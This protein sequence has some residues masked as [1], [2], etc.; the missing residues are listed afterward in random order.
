MEKSSNSQRILALLL[1]LTGLWFSVRPGRGPFLNSMHLQHTFWR[2]C[3]V[4]AAPPG[5]Q[6]NHFPFQLSCFRPSCA[7]TSNRNETPLSGKWNYARLLYHLIVLSVPGTEKLLPQ[8]KQ[9][10]EKMRAW[11]EEVGGQCI[12]GYCLTNCVSIWVMI[13]LHLTSGSMNR[14]TLDVYVGSI[15]FGNRFNKTPKLKIFV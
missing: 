5:M 15:K 1:Q 10:S 14:Q 12:R 4:Q 3:I 6:A 7:S 2:L 9:A 8:N 11:K 13:G